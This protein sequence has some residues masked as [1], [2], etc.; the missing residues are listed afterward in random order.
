M[1][2]VVIPVY[3]EEPNIDGLLEGVRERLDPLGVRY[4]L[5]IVD[6]GS[7]DKTAE[8]C[9]AASRPGSPI[10]V[11]SHVANS[12]PGAAFRTGFLAVL[13]DAD[14]LDIVVTMEGDR[15]SDERILTRLLHR[16]WEEGDDVVLASCYLYG[17]GIKGT[18]MHRVG[19]SHVANGLMK[20]TLGLSGLATLS[21]F[22]RAY[23]VSA[24][25]RMRD[26]WGDGFIK[27][28]GFECMVEV[29][30]R[31]AQLGLRVS[32]VPMVLDGGRRAGKSKMRVFKTSMAYFRLMALA[33]LGRL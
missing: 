4:R 31:A 12:G 5:V 3:N 25:S 22:Y 2:H 29:L 15:T 18:Q 21:S 7:T 27:S 6:D 10:V 28:R 23:Q 32:E 8:K 14:P 9:R 17:G 16:I 11:E 19:L 30:Y 13:R 1:I 24:L 26:R 20:K 33:R